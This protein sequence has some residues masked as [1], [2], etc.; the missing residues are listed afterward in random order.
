MGYRTLIKMDYEVLE[1]A[2]LWRIWSFFS[3]TSTLRL[4][5]YQIIKWN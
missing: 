5:L 1:A 3:K 4:A 2:S